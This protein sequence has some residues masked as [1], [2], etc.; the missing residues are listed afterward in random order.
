MDL[1]L[2]P[3][4]LGALPWLVQCRLLIYSA[5]SGVHRVQ[6]ILSG[7]IVRLFCFDQTNTLCRYGWIHFFA[8]IVLVCVDVMVMS[9][10]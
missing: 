10:A 1:R 6:V 8:A 9:A 4:P 2:D 3:E 7:V 5:G